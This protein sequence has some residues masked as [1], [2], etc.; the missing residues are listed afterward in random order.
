M[1]LKSVWSTLEE[2]FAS[3]ARQS[4]LA[5]QLRDGLKS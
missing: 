4:Y 5:S 3:A 2:S 1:N